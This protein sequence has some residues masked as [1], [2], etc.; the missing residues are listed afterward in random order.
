MPVVYFLVERVGSVVEP[1]GN[2]RNAAL[3]KKK[4]KRLVQ[5]VPV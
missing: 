2:E 4:K 1:A 3:L 5:A